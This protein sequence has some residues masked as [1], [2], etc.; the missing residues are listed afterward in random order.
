M[1][2][3]DVAVKYFSGDND[4]ASFEYEGDVYHYHHSAWGGGYLSRTIECMAT[5]YEGRFGS[6]VIIHVPSYQS[7]QY[8][9][10]H[11]YIK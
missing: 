9:R 7:S 4:C 8:H 5:I 1:K 11:Y 6:G 2:L 3:E 10:I